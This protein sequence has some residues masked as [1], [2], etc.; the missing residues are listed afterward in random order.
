MKNYK[1]LAIS[2]CLV[3]MLTVCGSFYGYKNYHHIQNNFTEYSTEVLTDSTQVILTDSLEQSLTSRF[4]NVANIDRNSHD[5]INKLYEQVLGYV[6]R[7]SKKTSK[8][9]QEIIATTII[10]QALEHDIDICF[11]L[12]QG[13][14]ETHL[15]TAGIGKSRRSIFG[16]GKTYDTYEDCIKYYMKLVRNA[17]LGQNKTIDDLFNDYSTLSGYR[18][19]ESPDYEVHLKNIY[20]RVRNTTNIYNLQ[21]SLCMTT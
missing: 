6:S 1:H 15:G 19:S 4:E 2:F 12:A 10:S 8:Y 20:N 7:T 5:V 17:Y 3:L 11:V 21:K 9:E 13:T 18:Y 14:L 16:V